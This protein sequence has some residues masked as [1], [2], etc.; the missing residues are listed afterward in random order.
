MTRITLTR[1]PTNGELKRLVNE[2]PDLEQISWSTFSSNAPMWAV[3]KTGTIHSIHAIRT[4]IDEKTDHNY[5]SR[6]DAIG[7]V[8]WHTRQSSPWGG[9]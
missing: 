4:L 7:A 3:R 8:W 9:V 2:N 6:L 5:V 1:E